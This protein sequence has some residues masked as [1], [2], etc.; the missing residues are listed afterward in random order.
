LTHVID[1]KMSDQRIIETR[2]AFWQVP[3]KITYNPLT[4][5]SFHSRKFSF[6]NRSSALICPRGR[7]PDCGPSAALLGEDESTGPQP[8]LDHHGF[9]AAVI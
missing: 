8:L 3:L 2:R 4:R 5:T 7:A 6:Q 1:M 9:F